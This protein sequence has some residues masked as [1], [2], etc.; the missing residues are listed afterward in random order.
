MARLPCQI[1]LI[2]RW[3][4]LQQYQ[5]TPTHLVDNLQVKQ[6][7]GFLDALFGQMIALELTFL[8]LRSISAFHSAT[9]QLQWDYLNMVLYAPDKISKIQDVLAWA[10]SWRIDC[11]KFGKNA[12]AWLR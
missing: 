10:S 1:I 9:E 3:V 2:A 5:C 6:Y 7:C 11:K 8:F 4:G 12:R